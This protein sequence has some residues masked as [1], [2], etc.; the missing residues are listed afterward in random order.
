VVFFCFEQKVFFI[1]QGFVGQPY[2]EFQHPL[3]QKG[4]AER[5]KGVV[6]DLELAKELN[7]S[8]SEQIVSLLH[9]AYKFNRGSLHRRR[10]LQIAA[11]LADEHFLAGAHDVAL[12]Y[13][14]EISHSRGLGHWNKVLQHVRLRAADCARILNL[15]P[16][17]VLHALDWMSCSSGVKELVLQRE[18]MY[19]EV[20]Q[21]LNDLTT[22]AVTLDLSLSSVLQ[23][24]VCWRR[25]EGLAVGGLL[26]FEEPVAVV[27]DIK[28]HF[29]VPVTDLEI[30]V[31][32]AGFQ[33]DTILSKSVKIDRIPFGKEVRVSVSFGA[34]SVPLARVSIARIVCVAF[35]GKL[36]LQLNGDSLPFLMV[37]GRPALVSILPRHVPDVWLEN[38]IIPISVSV[39]IP[40]N[41]LD[42]V[43]SSLCLE[44]HDAATGH[45]LPVAS[46]G[47]VPVYLLSPK[48]HAPI[49]RLEVE[50]QIK[51]GESIVISFALRVVTFGDQSFFVRFDYETKDY[52]ACTKLHIPTKVL[53]P[54]NCKFQLHR[55]SMQP[56]PA[57][58][59]V[60]WTN[61][62]LL[63]A[64]VLENSAE[65]PVSVSR[66]DLVVEDESGCSRTSGL[67]QSLFSIGSCL[68]HPNAQLAWWEAL[69]IKAS[70][71]SP[72]SWAHL[73]VKWRNESLGESA[74]DVVTKIPLPL[75]ASGAA[76]FVF[77]LIAPS[78][79]VLGEAF[80][81]T[82]RLTNHSGVPHQM[83][84]FT[85]ERRIHSEVQSYVLDGMK[86]SHFRV[87]PN[88]SWETTYR[89]ISLV[90]G[91]LPLPAFVVKSKRDN[92]TV[93]GSEKGVS[94][95]VL[96]PKK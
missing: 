2:E 58:H 77:N 5:D 1:R 11:A 88:S 50:E 34:C 3:E 65:V 81:V 76:P 44:Y 25:P 71:S 70:H 72:H 6:P 49:P 96:A 28:S 91:E 86:S 60:A 10:Q 22:E 4:L 36:L 95:S 23:L 54:F 92:T 68:L 8:H 62:T 93:E 87:L 43:R 57:R 37:S 56:L 69:L 13:Y 24:D 82:V 19:Q 15:S 21:R 64:S 38:D 80:E 29:P 14:A 27:V 26:P 48:T 12:N 51:A 32:L 35:G 59:A 31:E 66:I 46:D 74:C 53:K 17:F 94:V 85:R 63:I 79:A 78:C 45:T 52:S 83:F 33:T 40:A 20:L 30:V 39:Q 61:R 55:D 7:V 90:A 16:E 18:L 67:D 42:I 41:E 73:L 47:V 9:R 84:L 75:F 89:I